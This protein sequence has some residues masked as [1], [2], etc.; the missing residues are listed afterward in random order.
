MGTDQDISYTIEPCGHHLCH[1]TARPHALLL[2]THPLICSRAIHLFHWSSE[3]GRKVISLPPI[4]RSTRPRYSCKGCT[5][6]HTTAL[7]QPC[8]LTMCITRSFWQSTNTLHRETCARL[9]NTVMKV[10]HYCHSEN[11]IAFASRYC[12]AHTTLLHMG[13][14]YC[15]HV[16][17]LH[18]LYTHSKGSYST[19]RRCRVVAFVAQRDSI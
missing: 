7:A 13:N 9:R 3:E 16:Q 12:N 6:V 10:L 5:L 14:I 11:F 19:I 2:H 1:V 15:V 17:Q 8:A 4:V 18:Y